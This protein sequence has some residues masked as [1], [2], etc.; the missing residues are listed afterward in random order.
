VHSPAFDE[1]EYAAEC[2][3]IEM[4]FVHRIHADNRMVAASALA[5]LNLTPTVLADKISVKPAS[6]VNLFQ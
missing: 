6:V 4:P 3:R 5:Y 1:E 2:Q